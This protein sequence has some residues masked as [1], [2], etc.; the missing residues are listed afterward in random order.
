[1]AIACYFGAIDL[2]YKRRL[3]LFEAVIK[4]Q[5]YLYRF[6]APATSLSYFLTLWRKFKTTMRKDPTKLFNTYIS[7]AGLGQKS[8]VD[9]IMEQFPKLLHGLYRYATSILTCSANTHS[10]VAC[11]KCRSKILYPNCPICSNLKLTKY[12][13]LEWFHQ[14]SGI[15]KRPT[16][17]HCLT[18]EQRR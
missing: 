15:L 6:K 7:R 11:M 9:Q 3:E 16:S 13:F 2:G 4:V 10:I 17:K 12:H 5:Y 8:W 18:L 1:M 14:Y